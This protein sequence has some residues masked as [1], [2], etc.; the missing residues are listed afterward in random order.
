MGPHSSSNPIRYSANQSHERNRLC[1]RSCESEGLILPFALLD[2]H[3]NLLF[4]HVL[5]AE[6]LSLGS[7]TA[8]INVK[9]FLL[10]VYADM[11]QFEAI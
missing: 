9:L 4:G 3:R 1:Q 11:W 10:L 2:E 7:W 6:I 8:V 5:E